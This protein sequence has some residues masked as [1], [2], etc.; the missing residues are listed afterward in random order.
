MSFEEDRITIIMKLI[1]INL[2]GDSKMENDSLEIELIL[3]IDH[4]KSRLLHV[5]NQKGL[6]HPET[7]YISTRLDTLIYNYLKL[8]V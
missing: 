1:F 3:Q 4:L 8:K 2:P 5:A 6:T 7:V